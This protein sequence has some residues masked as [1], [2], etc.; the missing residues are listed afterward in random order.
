MGTRT[1]EVVVK[2]GSEDPRF[3][4]AVIPELDG[5]AA[6]GRDEADAIAHARVLIQDYLAAV[7]ITG[8]PPDFIYR[9]E[10]GGKR[11]RVEVDLP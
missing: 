6:Q 10:P 3:W 5:V 8:S 4:L 11:V 7:R 1:F 2:Q 9:P